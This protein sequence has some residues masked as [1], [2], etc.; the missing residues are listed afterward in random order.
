MAKDLEVTTDWLLGYSENNKIKE[1]NNTYKTKKG[2]FTVTDKFK[3]WIDEFLEDASREERIW[4][5]QELKKKFP[6]FLYWLEKKEPDPN[7]SGK[8]PQTNNHTA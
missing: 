8:P 2:N 5:E 6:D 4:L 1:N 7:G 3:I